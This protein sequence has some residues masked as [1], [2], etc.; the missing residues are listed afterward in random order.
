MQDLKI[1]LVQTSVH[2]EDIPA[3]LEHFSNLL[4][5]IENTDLIILPEMFNTGF[6]TKPEHVAERM[7]SQT[8]QWLKN[9][10]SDLKMA[11]CGSLIIK[12]GRDY[13]NRFVF[14]APG[15]ETQYY[16]KRHLFSMGN[17][18]RAFTKGTKRLVINYKG[19]NILP[20]ICYDLRFP[21][22]SKNTWK[23]GNYEF[24]LMVY[25]A[26]WPEVRNHAWNSLLPARAIENLAYV[27]AV[28]RTGTDGNGV[29]HSGDSIVLDPKGNPILTFPSYHE[30]ILSVIL[31]R[32]QLLEFRGNFNVGPD[33]D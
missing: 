30:S 31:S 12:D 20:M 8:M 24:D 1:T 21:V 18:D 17:E 14:V 32:K 22:W 29:N 15:G 9:K 33:W 26:S 23:D 16:D 27:A 11:V 5:N 2:W 4:S 13:F 28:S 7:D 25:V 6:T 19:W 3:N 10:A